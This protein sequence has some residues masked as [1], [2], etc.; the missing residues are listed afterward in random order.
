LHNDFGS[1][2]GTV[3][4]APV[5]AGTLEIHWP[6][7]NVLVDPRARSPLAKIPAYKEISA[8]LERASKAERR[9]PVLK[10]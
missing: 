5:T 4:L 7:G 8:M 1:Y 2:D 6:E 10:V 9:E 3:L